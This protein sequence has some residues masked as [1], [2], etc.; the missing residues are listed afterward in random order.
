MSAVATTTT[1][2]SGPHE[3]S[4]SKVKVIDQQVVHFRPEAARPVHWNIEP[5]PS[6][7]TTSTTHETPLA[8]ELAYHSLLIYPCLNRSVV[9]YLVR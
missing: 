6:T 5:L 2:D 7:F 4:R 1:L 3:D 9:K 8:S